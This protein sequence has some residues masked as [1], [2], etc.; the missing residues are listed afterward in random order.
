MIFVAQED[1]I[2]CGQVFKSK[3]RC[4]GVL[5]HV[6]AAH[7]P[8]CA[9]RGEEGID[10]EIDAIDFEDSSGS[11]DVR[12]TERTLEGRGRH[13]GDKLCDAWVEQELRADAVKDK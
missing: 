2:D 10:Q 4:V 6:P 3:S 7:V 9:S 12:D 8:C 11:T 13:F 5:E 1:D